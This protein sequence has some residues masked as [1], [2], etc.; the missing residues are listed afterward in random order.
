MAQN[1]PDIAEDFENLV[2]GGYLLLA[3]VVG[4]IVVYILYEVYELGNS[5]CNIPILCNISPNCTNCSSTAPTPSL[6][7]GPD[8][9]ATSEQNFTDIDPSLQD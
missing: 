3:L 7:Q 6:P 2:N 4:G 1:G 8:T 9:S 5:L